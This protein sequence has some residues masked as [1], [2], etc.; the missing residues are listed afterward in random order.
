MTEID[1][2][3]FDQ[4]RPTSR[5]FCLALLL[6]ASV[7]AYATDYHVDAQNGDD[8][9][10]GLAP[11]RA[12]RSLER[13]EAVAF[14]PGDRLLLRAGSVWH[15]ALLSPRGSGA[16]GR[17]ARIEP[18]G[19]GPKPALH[20]DGHGPAVIR[21]Q[22]Q[23]QWEIQGLEITNHS[24]ATPPPLA[25]GIEIRATDMGVVRHFVLRDLHI[26]DING[27]SAVFSDANIARKSY[28]AIGLL[29]EGNKVP[30]AW[31]GVLVERCHIHDVSYVGFA[32]VSSWARGHRDND[33]AA[34]FPSRNVVIRDNLF[35]RTARD[36]VIVRAAVGPLIER[37]RFLS[38]ALEGNGVG[39]FAFNCDGAVFQFNEAAYTRYNPGD[40]DA[41]GFDSDWNCRDTVIQYNYSHHN[42]R[43]FILLCNDGS[44]GFNERTIVRYNL[45]Y[46]DGGNIITFSGPVT[47]ARVYN[48]TILVVPEMK[49][50]VAG[51][52][53]RIVY[54]KTWHG[55]SSDVVFANN[56][57]ANGS[58]AAIYT[59]GEST[60]NR[61]AHNLFVGIHPPSEPA[62]VAPL[63]G[64]QGFVPPPDGRW[65]REEVV[66]VYTPPADSAILWH[67]LAQPNQPDHDFAHR[68]VLV[69]QDRVHVGALSAATAADQPTGE[70]NHGTPKAASPR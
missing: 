60:G 31:D 33:P 1:R 19:E 26:H 20:G 14:G 12:W 34:W 67:G 69:R 30:T 62:D 56:V 49:A 36:G 37:N 3:S 25:R 38:C 51:D 54:H 55:W 46:A 63:A 11:A 41:M 18:Y 65:S 9:S 52:P 42:D 48:N 61:Y 57:I 44:V 22:N 2:L 5:R 21:F 27:P 28:G 24:S 17:P 16:E 7:T 4:L 29:I 35:E 66:R 64:D 43:G 59:F 58:A 13:T 68:P 45:S 10:D 70:R 50:P 39:C 53:V 23:A 47:G 6:L 40:V 8:A 15:G 32:N